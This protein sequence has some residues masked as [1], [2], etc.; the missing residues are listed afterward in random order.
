MPTRLVLLG[1]PVA[2]SLS[3]RFQNAAL[4]HAGITC[5]YEALDVP[6]AR[7]ASTVSMLHA[8]GAG[9][10]V[11]IPHKEAVAA[12]VSERSPLAER[13]GAVNTF[14]VRDGALIGDNT[15]VVGVEQALVALLGVGGTTDASCA[16]LGAGGSAAA[17]LVALER[18][19]A[20]PINVWSRTPGRAEALR[21]RLRVH[22]TVHDS[23]ESAC[24]GVTLV[25]NATPLGMRGESGPVDP[26]ELSDGASVL[27]LVYRVG[28]T[29]W[30]RECRARGLRAHD[31]LRMLVEQGAAAFQLW[32]GVEPS[33][34]VM[35]GSLEARP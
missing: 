25:V 23:A 1:H 27:D 9:G 24:A 33:R 18:L 20:G 3:P 31:G 30:V 26:S 7:L 35:W 8:E 28:E 29:S 11:T 16:V 21:E 5:S 34:E 4:R 17:T 19:G 14:L 13:L 15:D 10:N 32:F 22:A 2:H 6:P 12:L